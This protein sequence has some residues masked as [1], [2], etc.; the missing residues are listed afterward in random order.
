VKEQLPNLALS[1]GKALDLPEPAIEVI[2]LNTSLLLYKRR[3]LITS[4]TKFKILLEAY[5]SAEVVKRTVQSK[6]FEEAVMDN[7]YSSFSLIIYFSIDKDKSIIIQSFNDQYDSNEK[8]PPIMIIA[9]LVGGIVSLLLCIIFWRCRVVS[10]RSAVQKEIIE[11]FSNAP[12]LEQDSELPEPASD[13]ELNR[14]FERDFIHMEGQIE[15]LMGRGSHSIN[16]GGYGV[17]KGGPCPI[18]E[19]QNNL[20]FQEVL[21]TPGRDS[22][23]SDSGFSSSKDSSDD[24]SSSSRNI[25]SPRDSGNMINI[26]QDVPPEKKSSF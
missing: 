13:S 1:I 21:A 9:S 10:R 20:Q 14:I 25:P 18:L 7:F 24:S 6:V 23:S 3:R 12:Q 2:T 11:M 5:S 26:L 22:S 15:G 19:G 8:M 17:T 16:D 4:S